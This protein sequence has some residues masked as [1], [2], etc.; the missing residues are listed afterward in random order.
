MRGEG[1]RARG[2]LFLIPYPLP[3]ASAVMG[4][5]NLLPSDLANQIAAGEVVERRL[6]RQRADRKRHRRRRPS[7]PYPSSRGASASS[8]WKTM[9]KG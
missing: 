4:I 6:G 8:V 9:A 7:H 1:Q 5:I 3:L 2:K